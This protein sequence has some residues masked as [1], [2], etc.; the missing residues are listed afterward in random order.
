MIVADLLTDI[1]ACLCATL[2]PDGE[3]DPGLCF[4]GVISGEG[5]D[6]AIG[7]ECDD[8]CGMAWVRLIAAYPATQIGQLDQT[9]TP[10]GTYLGLDIEVGVFR[11]AP[12][13]EGVEI[14]NPEDLHALAVQQADDMVLAR[15]AIACC[16]ALEDIDY[17]LGTWTPIGPEGLIMGG[18][19]ILSVVL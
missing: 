1:A 18:A 15:K 5:V 9:E 11:C 6:S 12:V 3:T 10:C 7:F 2:T 8:K 4:C 17:L 19:W 13:P 14:P 16:S